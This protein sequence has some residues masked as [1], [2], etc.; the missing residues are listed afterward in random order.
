[1][2]MDHLVLL[3]DSIFDPHDGRQIG[4]EQMKELC[5]ILAGM[6]DALAVLERRGISLRVHAVRL[7]P[8]TGKLPVYHVFL[9]R[10]EFWF[11]ARKELD[12]F[13]REQEQASGGEL[14]I[15]DA[16]VSDGGNGQPT[17]GN[18]TSPMPSVKYIVGCRG[19]G[20]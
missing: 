13:L 1:M 16:P 10:H 11:T 15:S 5:N 18:G 3:G 6:E 2:T 20:V 19:F 14:N 17:N 12:G 8:V 7:D 9:D 4:G